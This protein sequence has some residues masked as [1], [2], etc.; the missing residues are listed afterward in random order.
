MTQI[1]RCLKTLLTALAFLMP[2]VI[3]ANGD[4]EKVLL[5]TDFKLTDFNVSAGEGV[6]EGN[7]SG[8]GHLLVKGNEFIITIPAQKVNRKDKEETEEEAEKEENNQ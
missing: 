1:R 2:L 8:K 6:W 4:S 7:F 5:D 3:W